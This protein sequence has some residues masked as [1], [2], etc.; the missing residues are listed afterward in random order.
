MEKI[1]GKISCKEIK[2]AF[3]DITNILVSMHEIKYSDSGSITCFFLQPVF[4]NSYY[5][6]QDRGAAHLQRDK[7]Q[8][9]INQPYQS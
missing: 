9:F 4:N 5:Q 7:I 8:Y 3:S 6:Q 2:N 1:L